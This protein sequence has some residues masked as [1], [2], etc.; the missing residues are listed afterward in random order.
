MPLKIGFC[1][2]ELNNERLNSKPGVIP[3][4][5]FFP[6]KYAHLP[7]KTACIIVRLTFVL[8]DRNDKKSLA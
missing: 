7:Q 4:A 1:Y 8:F 2:A 3:P 5:R 6:S